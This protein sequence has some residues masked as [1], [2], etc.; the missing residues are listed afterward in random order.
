MANLKK[1]VAVVLISV[2]VALVV[3]WIHRETM[4]DKCLDGGGA[5]D[6]VKAR[7]DKD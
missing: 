1:L 3:V 6:Y 2:L 4:I 7:C 5:W